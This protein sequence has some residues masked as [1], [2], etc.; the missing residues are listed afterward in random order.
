[1]TS[2]GHGQDAEQ[3]PLYPR[4]PDEEADAPAHDDRPTLS[5]PGAAAELESPGDPRQD[6]H[7]DPAGSPRS[8]NWTAQPEGEASD[9]LSEE[10]T[11]PPVS[12]S[13][14]P[15]SLI[16]SFLDTFLG[17]H[18]QPHGEGKPSTPAPQEPAAAAHDALMPQPDAQTPGEHQPDAGKSTQ[19]PEGSGTQASAPPPGF[20]E[21]LPPAG[22]D[23]DDFEA[24][25]AREREAL[26]AEAQEAPAPVGGIRS[27][28]A[29]ADISDADN[30]SHQKKQGLSTRLSDQQETTEPQAQ[31]QEPP[32]TGPEQAEAP[33]AAEAPTPAASHPDALPHPAA[34]R[35]AH[36]TEEADV[37]PMA[38]CQPQVT[39]EV[40]GEEGRRQPQR[41]PDVI[42][43]EATE[44]IGRKERRPRAQR[45]RDALQPEP[46]QE[47]DEEVG[48]K[49]GAPRPPRRSF[50]D[51]FFGR[52][53]EPAGAEAVEG[54]AE[55]AEQ[56]QAATTEPTTEAVQEQVM[57]APPA[58]V[59]PPP[60]LEGEAPPEAQPRPVEE[61]AAGTKKT[62]PQA[63]ES[64]LPEAGLVEEPAVLEEQPEVPVAESR[65]G[66]LLD[67]LSPRG[68]AAPEEAQT[69][70]LAEETPRETKR[71]PAPLARIGAGLA[72]IVVAVAAI[73]MHEAA[74]LRD[75]LAQPIAGRATVVAQ[76]LP[77]GPAEPVSP[78]SLAEPISAE[79]LMTK[80]VP[81]FGQLL[82]LVGTRP[83]TQPPP[84]TAGRYYYK[85]SWLQLLARLEA[86]PETLQLMLIPLAVSAQEEA[87]R[88]EVGYEDVVATIE[89]RGSEIVVTCT[90]AGRWPPNEV[91]ECFAYVGG[92]TADAVRDLNGP[93][94][95]DAWTQAGRKGP[96]PV[97]E[98]DLGQLVRVIN[99]A[100][101]QVWPIKVETTTLPDG[102]VRAVHK[103]E[104]GTITVIRGSLSDGKRYEEWS[105]SALSGYKLVA[106]WSA[107]KEWSKDE[108]RIAVL[109]GQDLRPILAYGKLPLWPS[110][111]PTWCRWYPGAGPQCNTV[112]DCVRALGDA[113]GVQVVIN[114]QGTVVAALRPDG[115][116]ATLRELLDP[117]SEWQKRWHMRPLPAN[118][119]E[120]RLLRRL[121]YAT[122]APG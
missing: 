120:W 66:T 13:G 71:K 42:Q 90:E 99:E 77:T 101:R 27:E 113:T 91:F 115:A 32:P 36:Q 51:W 75:F 41:R 25:Q 29:G 89:P 92:E 81:A 26:E 43:P 70:E 47:T 37:Q 68:E 39:Q 107:N 106:I 100:G 121:R 114:T 97:T 56:P 111:T 23:P 19:S 119:R 21:T 2:T 109:L 122:R 116:H 28:S 53:P 87:N 14:S 63:L 3:L 67:D 80:D 4:Q 60:L 83:E 20:E 12:S 33:A 74:Q 84:A 61:P 18:T 86:P 55:A 93:L 44:E 58:E 112:E 104:K 78:Q 22:M 17:R 98:A 65:R 46:T 110:T 38:A 108:S 48:E 64:T 102:A 10:G 85:G 40:G 31:V 30:S 95:I 73:K 24:W 52:M 62:L 88:E 45:R 6:E 54:S 9:R 50:L 7:Q 69:E 57:A 49:E 8:A 117:E 16:R 59:A 34:S 5:T 103:L 94:A 105:A 96:K 72:L 82:S 35:E 1:M 11:R 118:E 15:R 76:P 79:S